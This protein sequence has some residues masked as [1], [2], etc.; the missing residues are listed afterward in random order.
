MVL[1][2]KK[3]LLIGC[4]DIDQTRPRQRTGQ[5][6]SRMC[7]KCP[8]RILFTCRACA[9]SAPFASCLHACCDFILKDIKIQLTSTISWNSYYQRETS[10]LYCFQCYINHL[11]TVSIYLVIDVWNNE[12]YPPVHII[13]NEQGPCSHF[14]QWGWG[15]WWCHLQT[16]DWRVFGILC[17]IVS[18]GRR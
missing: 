11:C 18:S 4:F 10:M 14:L 16:A 1:F 17:H 8:V 7:S 3:R 13:V 6:R 15:I 2:T 9:V 12:N 5:N